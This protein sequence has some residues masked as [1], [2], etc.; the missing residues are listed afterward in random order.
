MVA[1]FS[2]FSSIIC[3]VSHHDCR[4]LWGFGNTFFH[5]SKDDSLCCLCKFGIET[6]QRMP[7]MTERARQIRTPKS[8]E[9]S[10]TAIGA[11]RKAKHPR[12]FGSVNTKTGLF[13]A[14]KRPSEELRLTLEDLN[15]KLHSLDLEFSEKTLISSFYSYFQPE[16][17]T[18]Y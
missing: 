2:D 18:S 5:R 4:A 17:R 7:S 8:F 16:C 10:A 11:V 15:W 12:F 3:R 6:H 14:G 1:D 13:G 9:G